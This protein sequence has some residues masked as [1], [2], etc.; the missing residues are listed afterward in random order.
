VSRSCPAC[1]A[2][3]STTAQF[4][5][6]CGTAVPAAPP[7]QQAPVVAPTT[8][9]QAPIVPTTTQQAPIAPTTASTC[10]S[11]GGPL[12]SEARF[13]HLCG[14]AV[15]AD[16]ADAPTTVL[17]QEPV[18]TP[19]GQPVTSA[20]SSAQLAPE[21]EE[22][23]TIVSHELDLPPASGAPSQPIC[24]SCHTAVSAGA[25]FCRACGARLDGPSP[26]TV[27][28]LRVPA[29][30]CPNCQAQ[31]ETWASFCRHCGWSLP[32]PGEPASASTEAVVEAGEVRCKVCG[33]PKRGSGE[34]CS[35]CE[36][37]MGT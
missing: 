11:C 22:A 28:P 13:C 12:V 27:T 19:T 36:Q 18:A 17:A 7:A 15:A 37:A 29:P 6:G 24:P 23:A 20:S 31:V 4:C 5:R 16:S 32:T 34:L 2:E 25:R 10:G 1:G 3:V 8:T 26:A 21:G 33:A 35:Q 30:T 9:L 14:S